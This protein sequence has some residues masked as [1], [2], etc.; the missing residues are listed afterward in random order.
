MNGHHEVLFASC[1]CGKKNSIMLLIVLG[2]HFVVVC[3]HYLRTCSALCIVVNV[4]KVEKKTEC[5]RFFYAGQNETCCLQIS[6]VM[7]PVS[8]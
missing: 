6:S 2:S 8:G 5:C 1:M 3:F 4:Y 7:L